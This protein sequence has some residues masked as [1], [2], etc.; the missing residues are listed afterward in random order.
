MYYDWVSFTSLY[1]KKKRKKKNTKINQ[2]GFLILHT[3]LSNM[4]SST[5]QCQ[6]IILF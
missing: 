4:A 2:L 5:F 3:I 6:I 1:Y